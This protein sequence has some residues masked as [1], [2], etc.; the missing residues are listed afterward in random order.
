MSQSRT[1]LQIALGGC[2]ALATVMGIGRFV[3]TPILPWM[4]AEL[5]VDEFGAGLIASANYLGYLVGALLAARAPLPGGAYALFAVGLAL[6]ALTTGLMSFSGS[7]EYYSLTRF[8]SGVT[9]AYVFVLTSTLIIGRLGQLGK[10]HLTPVIFAGVGLG[11]FVSSLAIELAGNFP[12]T[13]ST[14][15]WISG[16]ASFV[17]MGCVLLL[18]PS[19]EAPLVHV[20]GTTSPSEPKLPRTAGRLIVAYGLFG[21]GYVITATFLGAIAATTPGLEDFATRGWMLV[22]LAI[23]PSVFL[24]NKIAL[25]IGYG[26]AISLACLLEAVGV[27]VS[28]LVP[29][30][31]GIAIAAILLGGTFVGITAIGLVEARRLAPRSPRSIIGLMTAAF[32]L[33]Q[34]IG[35]TFSGILFE[36]TGG[37]T[38]ASLVAA[39]AL[40]AAAVMTFKPFEATTYATAAEQNTGI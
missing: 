2:L 25:A 15:W 5:W 38:M 19:R 6:T 34:V 16:A 32:G 7:V 24:W 20:M 37:F 14:L 31:T 13:S 21:F 30:L 28:V 29:S 10:E 11:I 40:V 36:W 35:P 27:A 4:L 23:M 39:G 17:L 8:V 22:G 12:I 18:F 33:G 1:P 9:S 26:K 3:Y